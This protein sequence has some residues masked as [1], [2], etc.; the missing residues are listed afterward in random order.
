MFKYKWKERKMRSAAE[1]TALH[2][3][4]DTLFYEVADDTELETGHLSPALLREAG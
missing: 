1:L 2:N 3:L 4:W